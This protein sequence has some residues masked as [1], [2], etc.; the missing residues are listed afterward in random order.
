MEFIKMVMITLYARQQKTH[1]CKEQTVGLC[2]RRWRWYDL[3]E[4]HWNMYIIICEIDCQSR[5]DA[6]GRVLR[7]GALGWPWG[8]GWGREVGRRVRM[9]NT[10]TPMADSCECMTKPPQYCKVISLQLKKKNHHFIHT[11]N[12]WVFQNL[13]NP[14]NTFYCLTFWSKPS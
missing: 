12:L 10:Y 2:G 6:W 13:Y 14:N 4:N 1:R 11:R 5:F 7:A 9:G 8:M 3:R